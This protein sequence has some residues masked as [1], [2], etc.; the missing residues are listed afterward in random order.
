MSNTPGFASVPTVGAKV[1]TAANGGSRAAPTNVQTIFQPSGSAG[2]IVERITVIPTA[3]TIAGTVQIYRYDGTNY[4]FYDEIQ[5]QVVTVATGTALIPQTVEAVNNPNL[6]P[7]MIPPTW[8]LV[9][10]LSVAQTGVCVQAEG[11]SL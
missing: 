5:I 3:T 7:I 9:A 1:L 10:T 8:N 11:G 6:V 4:W 2:G